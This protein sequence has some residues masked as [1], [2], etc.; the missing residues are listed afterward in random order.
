MA[1]NPVKISCAEPDWRNVLKTDLQDGLDVDLT[2]FDYTLDGQF[3]ELLA[4]SHSMQFKL[5]ARNGAGFFRK[6]SAT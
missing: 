4:M 1:M 3:C 6:K 5:D 2:N